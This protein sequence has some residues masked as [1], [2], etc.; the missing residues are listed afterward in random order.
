MDHGASVD[1]ACPA[2]YIRPMVR[3]G[4]EIHARVRTHTKMFC[5]CATELDRA[6]S[7][8]VCPVCAGWPGAMPT[9]NRRVVQLA[10]RAAT[11]LGCTI[12]PVSRFTRKS[13]F[14][15]DLPKGY[16]I[17]QHGQVLA[18]HGVLPDPLGRRAPVA[19]E[20][21]HLEED[22]ARSVHQATSGTLLD[23]NRSGA[24]LV[25]IVTRPEIGSAAHAVRL[26]RMLRRMFVDLGVC[27]GRMHRGSLRVDAN[28]SLGSS[29]GPRVEIKNLNSLRALGA[30]LEYEMVRQRG[31]QA[32]GRRVRRETR[33]W[34]TSRGCSEVLRTKERGDDYRYMTEPDLPELV[35]GGEFIEACTRDLPDPPWIQAA[36]FRNQWSLPAPEAQVLGSRDWLAR[37]VRKAG[38]RLHDPLL[39]AHF[40]RTEILRDVDLD[41]PVCRPRVRA[42]DLARVMEMLE[43]GRITRTVAREAIQ[44]AWQHGD[45]PVAHATGPAGPV[46]ADR[47]Q[48]RRTCARVLEENPSLV[49]KWS[50]GNRNVINHLV[51]LTLRRS[52]ASLSPGQVKEVLEKL[53][54][55]VDGT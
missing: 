9:V 4:L 23:L 54:R 7:S 13:Y 16:Q 47:Q 42:E 32:A 11:S 14:Y 19:V 5:G 49:S 36:R 8:Q 45:D 22:T 30:A 43:Q 52:D 2:L 51:G 27:D 50:R 28:I 24:P 31:L 20:Q 18:T 48:V 37:H 25:E 44:R 1:L 6:P 17:T 53:L 39:A 33:S 12:H 35:L 55:Q 46:L 26:V 15:P 10:V 3:I 29:D 40:V 38:C 21:V 41:G 34:N